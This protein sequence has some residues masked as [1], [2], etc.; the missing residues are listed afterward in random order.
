MDNV[1]VIDNWLEN[2]Q[3]ICT[4]TNGKTEYNFNKFKLPLKFPSK[5]YRHDLTL[6]KAE[7]AQQKFKMLISK[8]N[9]DYNSRNE[10]KIKEKD[11]TINSA[12]KLL[13]IRENIIRAFKKGISSYIDGNR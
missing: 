2:A 11:G 5:I 6:Q 7:D 13:S 1:K 12:K 10:T 9:N 8:L 4:K 3:F